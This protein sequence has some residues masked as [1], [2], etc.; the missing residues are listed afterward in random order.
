MTT[1]EKSKKEPECINIRSPRTARE[2]KKEK[3]KVLNNVK[4]VAIGII[5][6]SEM[7]VND[8]IEVENKLGQIATAMMFAL[9]IAIILHCTDKFIDEW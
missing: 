2:I 1:T 9:L 4:N 5:V 6:A 7:L 3:Y 8:W